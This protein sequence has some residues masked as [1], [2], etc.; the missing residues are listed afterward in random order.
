LIEPGDDPL[1]LFGR[2]FEEARAR[3]VFQPEAMVV[4]SATPDGAPSARMVLMKGF[5]ERGIAFFTNYGSRKGAELEANPRA[6][7]LFHWSDLGRQVRVEG[8]VSRVDRSESEAYARSRPRASQL[9]AAA[10]PQSRPVPDREWLE[11]RVEELDREHADGE[12][13]LREDWGG[14]RVEPVA[15]EFW[16]HRDNRL[17]DRFRFDRR[18]GGGW[19][20][21]RLA[22]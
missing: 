14:Y 1:A 13:P 10:S 18:D 9:S 2:W 6:A 5:D 21:E 16:V 12:I 8:P 7:L 15:W 17:H 4:A 22:P 11:R 3:D 20:V 19:T